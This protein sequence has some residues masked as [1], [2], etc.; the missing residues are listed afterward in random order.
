MEI[1]QLR[2]FIKIAEVKNLTKSAGA[3]N[4]SQSALS[5]QIKSLE[6]EFQIS[7]FNRTPKGMFLTE[8]GE[9]LLKHAKIIA[10][11]AVNMT[12]AASLLKNKISGNLKI[13][14]NTDP[15]FLNISKIKRKI[16][17]AMPDIRLSFVS[18]QSF[19]THQILK[20][21]D[22][23]AGFHYGSIESPEIHTID[24]IDVVIRVVIPKEFINNDV[25]KLTTDDVVSFPW[26][27]T[28]CQC[29]FHITFQ[30]ELDR[31][32]LKVNK[33]SDAVDENIVREL[34]KAGTGVAIMR[35]DE[36]CYLEKK[37]YIKVWDG[38]QFTVPMKISCLKERKEEKKI[39]EV[40]AMISK[41]FLS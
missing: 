20:R 26:I 24:L 2:S 28:S 12:E 15:E 14:I 3:L 37:G 38:I 25:K 1:Y 19:E 32:G 17:M 22:I 8:H 36:A 34:V 35:Q 5:S 6:D 29:P 21:L 41:I 27:W 9:S 40:F 4:I 31:Y 30:K 7:L 11:S 33:T 18:S 16:T 23:D 13:G 10:S 39:Q